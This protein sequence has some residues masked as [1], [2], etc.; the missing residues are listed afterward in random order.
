M[1]GWGATHSGS[2]LFL[3]AL[4]RL[5]RRSGG[6]GGGRGV[7]GGVGWSAKCTGCICLDL[8]MCLY[9][10]FTGGNVVAGM[11]GHLRVM[12]GFNFTPLLTGAI[13]AEVEQKHS[14]SCVCRQCTSPLVSRNPLCC[15]FS[16]LAIAA[17][18]FMQRQNKTLSSHLKCT[19][20]K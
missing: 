8:Y 12:G 9:V 5:W 13:S 18:T 19:Q 14:Q 17:T 6:G 11:G 3:H 2:A 15:E 10:F 20:M 7:G 16:V 4:K 1:G